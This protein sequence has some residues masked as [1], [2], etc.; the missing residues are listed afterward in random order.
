MPHQR[1]FLIHP[2]GS[3]LLLLVVEI[4]GRN[5]NFCNWTTRWVVCLCVFLRCCCVLC[6]PFYWSSRFVCLGSLSPF[7][8]TTKLAA[9]RRAWLAGAN[10]RWPRPTSSTPSP[11]T[12]A[13]IPPCSP[14]R[15]E[16]GSWPKAFATRRMFPASAPLTGNHTATMQP[17]N[18]IA[19]NPFYFIL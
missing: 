17:I 2:Q 6:W 16:T 5:P 15:S 8:D 18:S 1:L 4:I 13:R 12:S 10:P 7:L 14:G 3:W 9:S 11:T 19:Q